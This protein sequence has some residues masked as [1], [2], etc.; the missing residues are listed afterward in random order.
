MWAV[1][2]GL[3]GERAAGHAR[4]GRGAYVGGGRS[5]MGRRVGR[6]EEGMAVESVERTAV[7]GWGGCRIYFN[8]RIEFLLMYECMSSACICPERQ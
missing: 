1:G 4:Q 3:G 2:A 6:R 8:V 5:A 7:G